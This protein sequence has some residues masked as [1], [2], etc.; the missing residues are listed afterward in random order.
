M[1]SQIQEIKI[2]N[3][4]AYKTLKVLMNKEDNKKN[5]NK[6]KKCKQRRKKNKTMLVR[7]NNK[8]KKINNKKQLQIMILKE[9][10]SLKPHQKS[11]VQIENFSLK[12]IMKVE[13]RY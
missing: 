13:K 10:V 6:V 3:L 8:N 9:M 5:K 11:M 1:T 2:Y 7:T 12:Q 4:N